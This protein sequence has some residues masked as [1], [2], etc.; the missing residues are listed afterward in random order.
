MTAA[1]APVG[2]AP[3][4]VAFAPDSRPVTTL[5]PLKV[6][7]LSDSVAGQ[8]CGRLL[9]DHG[10]DVTLV[11]PPAGCVTRRHGPFDPELGSIPFI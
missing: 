5:G 10:A 1:S 3:V 2:N 8:Y 7:D 11:E 9:A 6:L 4:R